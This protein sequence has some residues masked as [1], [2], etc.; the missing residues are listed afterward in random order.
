[1]IETVMQSSVL[2]LT[3]ARP[4]A[5]NALDAGTHEALVAALQEA[6]QRPEVEAVVLAASGSKA[7]S[8]GADL[9]EFSELPAG[10]AALRRRELLLQTLQALLALGKPV[11]AAVQAP[12]IG[13]GAMLALA[14]D[15]IV[16][17]EG[18][19][20]GFP[21]A[22]YG[23]PSPMGAALLERRA[24]WPVLQRVLQGGERCAA[25]D[26]LQAGLVDECVAAEALSARSRARAEALAA[27]P[28]HA[29]SVNKAWLNR[30]LGRELADA[31]AHATAHQAADPSN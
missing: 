11:V 2:W 22:K 26:A 28:S 5:A 7:Y 17:S 24:R 27:I 18:A 21:E 20:L 14:C 10:Q 31:A 1:M 9:R 25:F 4:Q 8:A 23:M 16:M 29:Y 3:I 12:A 13:A 19:W 15:E 6:A 30:A